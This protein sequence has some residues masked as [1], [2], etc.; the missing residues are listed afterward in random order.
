MGSQKQC[1]VFLT[2]R[3][4]I[5]SCIFRAWKQ[6]VLPFSGWKIEVTSCRSGAQTQ[7]TSAAFLELG[8]KLSK[9]GI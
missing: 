8:D 1:P 2:L 7:R 4:K 5:K 6:V 3:R 9:S